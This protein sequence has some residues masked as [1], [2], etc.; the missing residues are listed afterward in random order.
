MKNQFNKSFAFVWGV[1]FLLSGCIV[2]LSSV[3]GVGKTKSSSKTLQTNTLNSALPA[4]MSLVKSANCN[5]CHNA[6]LNAGGNAFGDSNQKIAYAALLLLI[7][8]TNPSN[9]RIIDKSQDAAH[10]GSTGKL[11][12][13]SLWEEKVGDFIKAEIAKGGTTGEKTPAVD[14]IPSPLFKSTDF[15]VDGA[16]VL[17]AMNQDIP[18]TPS[19]IPSGF[20][21]TLNIKS[22]TPVGEV[23]VVN[24]KVTATNNT[25]STITFS[26]IRLFQ[27]DSN[28]IQ[29]K[30]DY[31]ASR[32]GTYFDLK[33]TLKAGDTITYSSPDHIELLFNKNNS[34]KYSAVLAVGL[35]SVTVEAPVGKTPCGGSSLVLFKK[36]FES[37]SATCYGCHSP[38]SGR[39][40]RFLA[41]DVAACE[42]ARTLV[43]TSNIGNST[44][45]QK[46]NGKLN[47]GGGSDDKLRSSDETLLTDWINSYK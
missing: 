20:K 37:A 29:V 11:L 28:P 35:Q 17:T 7:D 46:G 27:N 8:K 44:I 14:D 5:A 38:A 13:Q 39:S 16:N 33:T 4:L 2:D 32:G 12:A 6:S 47:H 3:P 34:G 43:D 24:F 36:Y 31:D 15:T 23:Q 26:G 45:I 22:M 18:V 25:N 1:G 41:D 30:T 40:Y 21:L 19:G 42:N 9:S 10:Y